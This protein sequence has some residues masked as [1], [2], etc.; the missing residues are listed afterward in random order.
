MSRFHIEVADRADDGELRRVLASTP[1]PGAVTVAFQREPSFFDAAAVDGA[2]RQ[3]VI[4]RDCRESRIAGFG[5]RSVRRRYVNGEPV[6]V[7]YLNG[8]R[9][10]P[11]YRSHGLLA[12]G[13]R[14]FRQLHQ[15]G[16]ARLY[17]TTIAADNTAAIAL[18]TS[19]RA[20]LPRYYFAG[21]YHT[22][23][24]P[25]VPA[26]DGMSDVEPSCEIRSATD[27]DLAAIVGFLRA[28]GPSR[29]FFPC[30]EGT[31]FFNPEGTF[32]DLKA[33]DLL[34]AIR[35]GTV[36]GTLA[37]WD[38][39]AFRQVVVESYGSGIGLARPLYNGWAAL[40]KQ[41][42]LP[43]PGRPFRFVSAALPMVLND[44]PVVFGA[45]LNAAIKMAAGRHEYLL[46][47][48][49]DSDPLLALVKSR[50]R[51]EYLTRLYCVCWPDGEPVRQQIDE[52]P[53]YLEL[54][55]L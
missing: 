21:S 52:R 25:L 47:G 13:Y 34:V 28:A 4:A 24:I 53:P 35:S 39:S 30:Y 2:F 32:R 55:C 48:M 33:Q 41:P 19:G 10:L 38:Q 26:G 50:W 15:D 20:G 54:G 49:H 16:R 17:L 42:K 7:G 11:Q 43:E 51:A 5:T 44:E 12:R 3:T 37:C 45:L 40:R 9:L 14:F 31:D 23:V 29:Q 1:M 22:V 27:N 8:L 36:I 46:I 6:A 18:L